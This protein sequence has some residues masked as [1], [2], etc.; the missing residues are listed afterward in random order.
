MSREIPRQTSDLV[1]KT[2]VQQSSKWADRFIKAA[3]IQGALAA[4]L[5]S[6]LLYEGLWG[7][8]A[9][10]KIVAGGGAGTWLLV[11]YLVYVPLGPIAAAVTALFYQHLEAHMQKPY[12]GLTNLLAWGHIVLMNVGVVGATWLMMNAGYRGGASTFP[13]SQG[14]LGYSGANAG[15]VHANIM[16]GYPPYIGA[17]IAIAIV[18][19]LAGGLGYVLNWRRHISQ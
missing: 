10:S 11:G 9:A 4:V 1:M 15:L 12:T 19:A 5:T 14:G 16:V 18:G 6:Y 7:T 8:P 3:I 2:M 17:F 13:V